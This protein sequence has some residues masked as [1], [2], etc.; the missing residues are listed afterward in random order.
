MNFKERMGKVTENSIF[1]MD[2]YFV[3]CGTMAKGD[4]GLYY[5]YFSFWKKGENV[6][7]KVEII[8]YKRN[9]RKNILC[10]NI[11]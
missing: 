10:K 7:K 8:N 9:V 1:K 6:A 4:D 2:G 3:W 5:L 11:T